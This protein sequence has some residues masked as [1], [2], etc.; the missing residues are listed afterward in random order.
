MWNQRA[1]RGEPIV[2]DYH[3]IVIAENPV[4]VWDIDTLLGLPIDI[5]DYLS[6]SFHPEMPEAFQPCFRVVHAD[7]FVDVFASDRSHMQRA[8]GSY[9]KPPPSWPI[10][11][12]PGPKSNLMDFVDMERT[13]V[14]EVLSLGELQ[15][16]FGGV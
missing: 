9:R 15:E 1:G 3:V 11:T 6:G 5:S 13:F 7:V 4:E 10:I 2:W 16:R 12:S 14:G 8:D